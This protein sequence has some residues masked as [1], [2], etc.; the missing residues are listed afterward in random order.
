MY[1]LLAFI[2]GIVFCQVI[3]PIVNAILEIILTACEAKKSKYAEILTS[4]Q[5][6]MEKAI[7]EA[8]NAG[9]RTHVIGFG[10]DEEEYQEEETGGDEDDL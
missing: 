9:G 3:L 6:R 5:L 4:T 7:S 10:S 2:A 1:Y 8:E